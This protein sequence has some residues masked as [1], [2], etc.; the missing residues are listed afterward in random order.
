MPWVPPTAGSCNLRLATSSCSDRP[1]PHRTCLLLLK[2][3]NRLSAIT[4]TRSAGWQFAAGVAGGGVAYAAICAPM[5]PNTCDT[6]TNH[7][8]CHAMILDL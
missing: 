4:G 3:L 5:K 7:T 8:G 1:T 6:T 2:L